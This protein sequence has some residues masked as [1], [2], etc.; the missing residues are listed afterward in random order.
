[1]TRLGLPESNA[2]MVG[3]LMAEAELQGF[4][5]HDVIRLLLYARRIRAGGLNLRRLMALPK[6]FC[7]L[8]MQRLAGPWLTRKCAK[9]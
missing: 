9:S 4:D 6:Q 2:A 8:C 3:R 7:R 5:G 1:M